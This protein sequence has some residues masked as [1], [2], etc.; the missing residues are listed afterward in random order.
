[1]ASTLAWVFGVVFLIVGVLGT[2]SGGSV[3]GTFDV[4][5]LQNIVH[6]L[7]GVVSVIA[8]LSGEKASRL[9][10]RVFGVIY[11][12]LAIVGFFS[13]HTIFGL[14]VTN[15]ADN[16]FHAVLAVVLLWSGFSGTKKHDNG[17]PAPA[18]V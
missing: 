3:F 18:S 17:M 1:M 14:M 11:A 8:A 13:N 5:G 12:L 10:L 7:S 2:F 6:L 15:T 9:S 4:D 16:I